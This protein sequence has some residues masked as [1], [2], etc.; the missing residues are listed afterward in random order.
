[1]LV[2]FGICFKQH[3]DTRYLVFYNPSHPRM[4]LSLDL[5]SE[6]RIQ[7]GYLPGH[8]RFQTICYRNHEDLMTYKYFPQHSHFEVE[9]I[10]YQWDPLTKELDVFFV[11]YFC[12]TMILMWRH[13]N[14]LYILWRKK[15]LRNRISSQ[16]LQFVSNQL[17]KRTNGYGNANIMLCCYYMVRII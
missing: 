17:Q 14:G 16:L 1:M 8:S 6:Y 15:I 4:F 9:S 12:F 7:H 5:L 3:F 10:G 13:S 2:T 11:L